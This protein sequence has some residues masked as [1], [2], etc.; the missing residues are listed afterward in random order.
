MSRALVGTDGGAIEVVKTLE[1]FRID[2][3]LDA[4]RSIDALSLGITL[5]NYWEEDPTSREG[6]ESYTLRW[7]LDV[8]NE[9]PLVAWDDET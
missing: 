6:A 5:R 2:E 4:I 3:V 9:A 8:L 7:Q 1:F